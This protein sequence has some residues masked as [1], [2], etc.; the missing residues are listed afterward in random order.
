MLAPVEKVTVLRQ[1]RNPSNFVEPGSLL[2][3]LKETVGRDS[4]VSTTTRYGLDGP[5]I[6]SR[7]RRDIPHPPDRTWNPPSLQRSGY[8]V[9]C[10]GVK[11]RGPWR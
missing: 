5:G 2:P 9:C 3:Y 1:S 6:D 11:R 4:I 8:W 10:P 7:R